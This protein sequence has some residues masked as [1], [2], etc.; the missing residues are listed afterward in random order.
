MKAAPGPLP[1]S[2]DWVFE[3]KWDGHRALVRVLRGQVDVVSSTGKGRLATWPWITEVQDCLTAGAG[4]HEVV[5]DGEVVA[6]DDQG[7]HRFEYVGDATRAHVLILFD[8][9]RAGGASLLARP[10][11][12]RR[13]LLEALVVPSG[14]CSITPVH[15]DGALLW[16]V[17]VAAG[18]EGVVA[19]RRDSTYQPGRRAPTWRKTKA[20]HVQEFVVGGW[21]PGSGRREGTLGSLLLGVHD[22]DGSL[23]FVGA[24]GS[25]F[26]DRG[27]DVARARLA[28][29]AT[30]TCPFVPVPPRIVSTKAVWCRPTWVVQVEFAE[31]TGGGQLRHPVYLG[32]RDDVDPRSVTERP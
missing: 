2:G 3:P 21:L 25:G 1:T 32:V 27:L 10:W 29:D 19:K 4:D 26:D 30:S 7:R 22:A 17:I 18:Y 24:V 9:L 13:A 23:R 28:A 8:V 6:M 16:D 14:R 5:L 11:L 31:W 20:R 15:D 12:E